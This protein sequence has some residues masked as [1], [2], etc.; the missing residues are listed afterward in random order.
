MQRVLTCAV[1][2]I[3][4]YSARGTHEFNHRTSCCAPDQAQTIRTADDADEGVYLP[5]SAARHVY[6]G[7]PRCG[8]RIPGSEGR[9][10]HRSDL[11]GGGD[12]DGSA[13]VDEGIAAGGKHRANG[14]VDRRI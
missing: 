4:T 9:H 3:R 13:A 6:D 10:D 8:E 2:P 12:R 1:W 11:P 5:G 7:H 14:G